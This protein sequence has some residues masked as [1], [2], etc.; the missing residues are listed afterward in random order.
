MR[1]WDENNLNQTRSYFLVFQ[2]LISNNLIEVNGG[3]ILLNVTIDRNK[4][5]YNFFHHW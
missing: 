3:K 1:S 2:K 5:I 4:K